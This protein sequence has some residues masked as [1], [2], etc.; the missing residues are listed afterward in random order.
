MADWTKVTID[1]DGNPQS[2]EL[3]AYAKQSTQEEMLKALEKLDGGFNTKTLEKSINNLSNETSNNS[4]TLK[5]SMDDFAKEMD[6]SNEKIRKS[7]EVSIG[8]FTG[9]V[10]DVIGKVGLTLGGIFL[11]GLT[12]TAGRAINLGNVF[13]DLTKSGIAFNESQGRAV[14]QSL[15]NFNNLGI[16]TEDATDIMLDNS[17]V[18]R[19]LTGGIANA[20]AEFL[21]LTSYGVNLGLTLDDSVNM[22]TKELSART[23]YLNLGTVDAK[24][25]SL[26]TANIVDTTRK[27]VIYAQALGTSVEAIQSFVRNVLDDNGAF[28]SALLRVPTM[29][30]ENLLKGATDFLGTMRALGGEVGGEL[31]AATLEAATFGALG[32]SDAAMN[33]VTVLPSL[34]STMNGAIR[35]F[36]SGV[37]DGADVSEQFAQQLGNLSNVERDRIFA[38]ARAGDETAKELAKAVVQFEQS[39]KRLEKMGLDPIPVQKGF[40]AFNVI[41]KRFSTIIDQVLNTFMSGFGD[42]LLDVTTSM[43]N[44]THSFFR[45]VNTALGDAETGLIDFGRRVGQKTA[46]FIDYLDGLMTA[47]TESGMTF[48]E[49]GEMI[50]VGISNLLQESM[51]ALVDG[52][53]YAMELLFTHPKVI[54]AMVALITALALTR[55]VPLVPT[56]GLKPS[57]VIASSSAAGAGASIILDADGKPINTDGPDKPKSPKKPGLGKVVGKGI[58]TKVLAPIGAYLAVSEGVAGAQTGEGGLQKT[59]RGISSALN[60]LSFGL[61]GKSSD[62][63]RYQNEAFDFGNKTLAMANQSGSTVDFTEETMMSAVMT[64][65]TKDKETQEKYKQALIKFLESQD[66]IKS[67]HVALNNRN[68]NKEGYVEPDA[69]F[70]DDSMRSLL[71]SL[72]RLIKINEQTK[73]STKAIEQNS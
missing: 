55:G 10:F 29:A 12:V 67:K 48:K 54:G 36:E 17:Q 51:E 23:E 2:V 63:Y 25:R 34:A 35:D 60:N 73:K 22:Y 40:N 41:V 31:G 53:V 6:R 61:I 47:L 26:L 52:L 46:E 65:F 72:N 33:F 42:G 57:T 3:P 58:G 43:E 16:S 66:T 11:T 14:M 18:T 32:F 44:L 24:Q 50:K 38:F 15:I 62:E 64:A 28:S 20:T 8:E 39:A 59:G 1:I 71:Q 7:Y 69:T 4:Q 9:S 45:F 21:K 37:L 30:R 13:N 49:L 5:K 68:P 27:Q 56:K 70:S 19:L